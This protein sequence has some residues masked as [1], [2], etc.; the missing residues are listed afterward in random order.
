[1]CGRFG[2]SWRTSISSSFL[3]P[4]HQHLVDCLLPTASSQKKTF[5]FACVPLHGSCAFLW[6]VALRG[7]LIKKYEIDVGAT[8]RLMAWIARHRSWIHNRVQTK[9]AG[10]TASRNMRHKEYDEELAQLCEIWLF[11]NHDADE[12]MLGNCDG[13]KECLL[14]RTRIQMSFSVCTTWGTDEESGETTFLAT[15][16]GT[17]SS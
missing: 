11:R 16:P 2:S 6:C 17:K 10:R 3:F 4:A 7:Q 15:I 14:A 12:T 8:H 1:M 5:A 9:S 13:S